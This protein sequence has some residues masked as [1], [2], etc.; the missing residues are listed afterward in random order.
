[1]KR[2]EGKPGRRNPTVL[3][4]VEPLTGAELQAWIEK[5]DRDWFARTLPVVREMAQRDPAMARAYR[6]PLG[7]PRGQPRPRGRPVK[8]TANIRRLLQ[9]EYDTLVKDGSTA[10]RAVAILA[11]RW[12]EWIGTAKALHAVDRIESCKTQVRKQL[13]AARK[14]RPSLK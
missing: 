9:L 1:M 2:R 13:H 7:P 12:M 5:R 10:D 8:W 11:H 3:D 4:D 14:S 6:R